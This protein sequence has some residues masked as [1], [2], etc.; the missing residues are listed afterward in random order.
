MIDD[1]LE[2]LSQIVSNF[3]VDFSALYRDMLNDL[4]MK[5]LEDEEYEKVRADV[6]KGT[7][8]GDSITFISSLAD[9]R[10][11]FDK[12][13]GVLVKAPKGLN[14]LIYRFVFSLEVEYTDTNTGPMTAKPK[15][16]SGRTSPPTVEQIKAKANDLRMIKK[17]F[18]DLV[19]K[20]SRAQKAAKGEL[21]S[22]MMRLLKLRDATVKVYKDLKQYMD[23]SALASAELGGGGV[24]SL[25]VFDPFK[26]KSVSVAS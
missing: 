22:E 12:W 20:I 21:P 6:L 4:M 11:F 2:S 8:L 25:I 15:I 24:S 3:S 9:S 17:D 23:A 14:D 26:R 7:E 10:I 5:T 18:M 1:L 19:E 13:L 16:V